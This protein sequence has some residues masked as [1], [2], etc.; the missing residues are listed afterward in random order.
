[1]RRFVVGIMSVA[2]L[3][4][5]ARTA[6]PQSRTVSSELRTETATIDAIDVPTRTITLKKPDDLVVT[7]VAGPD[8]TRFAEL[9]VGDQVTARYY[10]NM[11]IRL[12]L[13]GEPDTLGTETSTTGAGLTL[14]GGTKA[15]QRTI[16]ATI[17]AIDMNTPS[18]TFTG[19]RGLRYTSKVVD[20]EAL[21]KVNIGNRVDI[22]WTD[23]VLVSVAPGK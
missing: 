7:V 16:S 12:K 23:A 9:K 11:V 17:T 20:K 14:P 19:P 5:M 1:M 13:P 22:I 3:V 6:T 2:V 4:L 18:V 10:E 15:T 21:A 8:I